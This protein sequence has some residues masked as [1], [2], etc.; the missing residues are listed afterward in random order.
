MGRAH[1]LTLPPGVASNP[2]HQGKDKVALKTLC[3]LCDRVLNTR[4][5]PAHKNS[6]GHRGR[7]QAETD[8]ENEKANHYGTNTW[9]G[10]APGFTPEGA[11]D[12]ASPDSGNDGWGT[13]G[14]GFGASSYSNKTGGGGSGD[15]RACFSCGEVG[16][17]KAECPKSGSGGGQACFNCGLEGYVL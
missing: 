5:W 15:D 11:F 12:L 1:V 3:E 10:D 9:G 17:R 7:E 4:D 8:K 6:K 16:H 2:Y 13:S 14:N